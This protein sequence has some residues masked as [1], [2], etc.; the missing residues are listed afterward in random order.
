MRAEIFRAVSD[1]IARHSQFFIGQ[2]GVKARDHNVGGLGVGSAVPVTDQTDTGAGKLIPKLRRA[3]EIDRPV[4]AHPGEKSGS[5][6]PGGA[7]L[8]LSR[9]KAE[10][11][12]LFHVKNGIV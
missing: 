6:I 3:E 4:R 2:R 8:S 1:E 5:H 11:P 9:R 12:E 7:D 10:S